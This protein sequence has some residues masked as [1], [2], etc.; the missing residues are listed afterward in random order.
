M[1]PGVSIQVLPTCIQLIDF[2]I[3]QSFYLEMLLSL[4]SND[5]VK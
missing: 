2:E 4:A 5:V 3:D 1:A